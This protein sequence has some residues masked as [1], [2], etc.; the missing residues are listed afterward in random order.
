MPRLLLLFLFTLLLHM[1]SWILSPPAQG[2]A[3]L[4]KMDA[5]TGQQGINDEEV[6]YV[7][8]DGFIRVLDLSV[9]GNNPESMWV[10]PT[11]N[12]KL[13]TTGWFNHAQV[14]DQMVA[15]SNSYYDAHRDRTM[16]DIAIFEFHVNQ[17]P[18]M[19]P[20][21]SATMLYT[22]AVPGQVNL[23]TTGEFDGDLQ[24]DEILISYKLHDE[25][26]PDPKHHTAFL[27]L[28]QTG[29]VKDGIQWSPYITRYFSL[30]W[31]RIDVANVDLQG[32]D[33]I[34]VVSH[35]P[36]LMRLY[37]VNRGFEH[38]F[39]NAS[40]NNPWKDAALGQLQSG[41]PLELAGV[42]HARVSLSTL[43]TF[44]Y[45]NTTMGPRYLDGYHE[46]FQPGPDSVLFAD[47]NGNG[48]DELFML[49]GNI[50]NG[51]RLFMRNL[52]G[53]QD[54]IPA[55]EVSLDS[56]NGFRVMEAGDTDSDHKDEL[57]LMR[58]NQIRVF[59]NPDQNTTSNNYITNTN[60]IALAL[61][62]LG[63]TRQAAFGVTVTDPN[64]SVNN[65]PNIATTLTGGQSSGEYRI[66]L[67]NIGTGE[68]IAYDPPRYNNSVAP[69]WLIISS[70]SADNQTPTT[71]GITFSATHLLPGFYSTKMLI[72]TSNTTVINPSYEIDLSLTVDAAL[73]ID[74]SQ[75]VFIV[76]PCPITPTLAS[77]QA[78]QISVDGTN[79]EEFRVTIFGDNSTTREQP[80]H[81]PSHHTPTQQ[82][83][84]STAP[85]V[86]ANSPSNI[87][88]ST[89]NLTIDPS[90][91]NNNNAPT[92][93]L[94]VV[95]LP[96]DTTIPTTPAQYQREV[97]L[98]MLC[99]QQKQFIPIISR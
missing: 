24:S 5:N 54:R 42:R 70:D 72:Q 97:P 47:V 11:G 4:E 35:E 91:R 41:G 58:D 33:E 63:I 38:Y 1:S 23:I 60:G 22:S 84:A 13:V 28:H 19:P 26:K 29:A 39:S 18:E 75:R 78:A 31:D 40:D 90:K 7:D 87:L 79:G 9:P 68:V 85:W 66:V 61:G 30:K 92:S 74:T 53:D 52:D 43:Y 10:S 15:V 36:G 65:T 93:N 56:D 81:Y 73:T 34:A 71:Y 67:D 89:I 98:L 16:S 46:R 45:D 55:F 14:H 62:D 44:F 3:A 8:P 76:D 12:W 49:R 32:I 57:V 69:N 59:I 96:A 48:D 83:W 17:V 88:P 77:S 2:K 86:S 20:E 99:V 51:L 80:T 6:I 37:H 64:N 82:E 95:V 27:I 94:V 50:N 21:I 25:D